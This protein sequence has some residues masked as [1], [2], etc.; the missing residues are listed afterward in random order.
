MLT[1]VKTGD[2]LVIS[3]ADYNAFV[4]AAL[5]LRQR[6][7]AQG[8]VT[9][10]SQWENGP[11]L[12]RN[13]SGSDVGRFYVLGLNG[14]IFTPTADLDGF[15]N[16]RAWVGGSPDETAHA[17]C[18]FVITQVPIAAGKLGLACIGGA[19][20]VQVEVTNETHAFA[21]VVTGTTANLASSASGGAQI[22]WKESGTGLK[23]ALVRLGGGGGGGAATGEFDNPH[24]L[25]YTGEHSEDART[26]HYI[27][28]EGLAVLWDRDEPPANT[29]GVKVSLQVGSSYYEAGAKTL[30]GYFVDFHIDSAGLVKAI[31]SERRATVD[32]PE[33]YS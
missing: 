15:K 26:D 18:K 22:L 27:N 14:P 20:P 7:L 23:W 33:V 9:K 8:R 4:D 5:D 1:K 11:V 17:D 12:V 21:D 6:Q 32:V 16:H 10:A 28:G 2:P 13:D 24:N 31:T 25:T 29:K 19:T 30:Y 3:A